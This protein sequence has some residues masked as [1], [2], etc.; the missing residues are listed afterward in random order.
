MEPS[1]RWED[2]GDMGTLRESVEEMTTLYGKGDLDALAESY[3]SDAVLSVPSG[4]YEGGRLFVTTGP[5]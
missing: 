5:N 2:R 3:A 1:R 4:R